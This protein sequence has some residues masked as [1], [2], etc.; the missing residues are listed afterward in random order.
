MTGKD[1]ILVALDVD[2]LDQVGSLI[3]ELA[4]DVGGFKIGMQLGTSV[5][6][7][8]ACQ[9]VHSR[10]GSVF[11]D[12]KFKDIGNTVKAAARAAARLGVLMFDVHADGGLKMMRAA[13]EGRNEALVEKELTKGSMAIAITVL[14]SMDSSALK[15]IGYYDGMPVSEQVVRLTALA[16]NS[17]LDGV[18]ASAQEAVEIRKTVCDSGFVI[19]TPA[20]RPEWATWAPAGDQARPTTHVEAVQ[21]GADYIVVGRPLLRAPNRK[22][23]A[24]RMAEE[25]D[26]AL[27]RA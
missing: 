6:V 25:M 9:F 4:G 16:A 10:G 17:G 1:R 3:E 18:V 7:P 22:E 19:I 2:D 23:A 21:A 20:I 12:Q 5:G 13:V 14:T 24:V 27:A 15:E 26:A 8:Q 11:L